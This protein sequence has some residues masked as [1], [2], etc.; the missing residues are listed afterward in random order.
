M[1]VV[2][3]GTTIGGFLAA[4]YSG[5][6]LYRRRPG[7]DAA[8]ADADPAHADLAR[9]ECGGCAVLRAQLADLRREFEH[10]RSVAAADRLAARADLRHDIG[11]LQ[12]AAAAVED[13]IDERVA[14][15]GEDVAVLFDRTGGRPSGGRRG[16]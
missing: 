13:D 10:E 14:G 16:A 3:L 15:L 12:D 2:S 7:K 6:T 1:D 4:A 11:K 8:R 5:W 9:V